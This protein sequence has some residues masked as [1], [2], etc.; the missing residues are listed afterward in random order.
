MTRPDSFAS[1]GTS[2]DDPIAIIG[3]G[4][5]FPGSSD[6]PR[7]FWELMAEGRDGI[8][9]VPED[10]WNVDRFWDPDPSKPGKMYVK[11][12]G[13]LRQRIDQ[14][15]ALFFGMSPREAE[16][17]DP[18]QRILLEVAWEAF[19]DAGIA[20]EKLAGS[21][22]GVYIGG[23]M[24]DGMLTQ[25][26]PLNRALIGT[27]TAVSS[28]LSI[29]ANRLSYVFD[30]RGPNIAMDTACSSSLVAVHQA[31]QALRRKECSLALAGGVNVMYRPEN[32]IS[33]CK[34]GFLSKDGRSKSFDARADGYGRGEGA[35]IVVL[36]KLSD[37]L[38]DEDEIYAVIRGT[39]VNQDGRTNGITVPNPES[40]E[41][42]VRR[43]CRDAGVDPRNIRYFE[44]HG[45]GTSVGDPLEARALGAVVGTGRDPANPCIV[46]SVKA[47]I[48]HLEAAS[49]VAGIIK[50]A[51]CL[52][53]RQIPPIANLETPNPNI[54]FEE[55]GLRLPKG[56]ETMPSGIGPALVGVNS[57]G[58]GGTNA[59]AILEEAP[60]TVSNPCD[61]TDTGP[62][63]LPFSARSPIALKTLAS[64]YRNLV[65]NDSDLKLRDLSYSASVRRS[66]HELRCAVV[67]NTREELLQRLSAV[68]E[69]TPSSGVSLGDCAT[70]GHKPVFVFSGMG[71]Q[72]WAM[73]RELYETDPVFRETASKVDETFREIAG[74]S[75]LGEMLADEAVSR[76][77]ETQIAQP[78]NF[79]LQA[80]LAEMWQTRGIK[81]AAV[82]GHSVGEVTA[83][84]LAGV[85]S[86]EDAVAVSFHRSRIQKK[87]AGLG[88]MLAVGL[89]EADASA[90]LAQYGDRVSVAAAN[91]PSSTTLAGDRDALESIAA[92][93]ER[94]GV[95]NRFLRVE[96]AYHS[97][98][99]DPLRPELLDSLSALRPRVPEIPLYSTVTGEKVT[100]I[101]Y[102]A[103]YWCRNVREPVYF[104]RA[105]D[106]ML[107]DG[108]RLFL[109]VGPHPVLSTSIREC[110]R[111]KATEC[112]VVASLRRG[113]PE[114]STFL[115]GLGEL[116]TAGAEID[117]KLQ[118]PEG[119]RF[120]KM[121]TYP[122]QRE[123]YWHESIASLT[124][125]LGE[126]A[127]PLLGSRM[128][129]PE[130]AWS[131]ALNPNFLPYLN[132]HKVDGLVVLPGAAYVELGF[133]VRS[134]AGYGTEGALEDLHFHKALVIGSSEEPELR[135]VYHRSTREFEIYSRNGDGSP[136]ML[137]AAG[138]LSLLSLEEQ[139]GQDM[140][141]IRARCRE[142]REG[143]MH[144]R[145]MHA[146]G[147]EYGP[148]FQ[149]VRELWRDEDG[150]E[151]LA[152]IERKESDTVNP[153][154]G[155]D[156]T[157][158]DA[159]FQ[160]LLELLDGSD[161]RIYVPVSIRRVSLWE[162]LGSRILCHGRKTG[163]TDDTLV[164]DIRLCDETGKVLAEVRGVCAKALNRTEE[165]IQANLDH[166]FYEYGWVRSETD[167]SQNAPAPSGRWL[168]LQDQRGVGERVARALLG[169]G[170]EV[171]NVRRGGHFKATGESAF[172]VS[173]GDREELVR[174]FKE[175]N[176]S[177]LNGIL[178]FWSLDDSKEADPVG[179]E[180]TGELLN[181]IQ[182]LAEV[183]PE[184]PAP[185][186]ILTREAQPV[187]PGETETDLSETPLVG[188][189]R[190]AANEYPEQVFRSID[191][192]PSEDSL[193]LLLRELVAEDGEEE[194][195]Y[196]GGE[197]YVRRL[198]RK[199]GAELAA[200]APEPR[201][202]AAM[203]ELL[204]AEVAITVHGCAFDKREQDSA[205]SAGTEVF[206]TGLI[207]ATARGVGQLR[208]GDPV[209]A[210]YQGD[211]AESLILSASEVVPL[212]PISEDALKAIP[213]RVLPYIMAHYALRHM[214]RIASG[215]LVLIHEADTALGLA[216]VQAAL[217]VGAEVFV[218]VGNPAREAL[219]K[220][221]GPVRVVNGRSP[222]LPE[223]VL[224]MTS[225]RGVDAAVGV[226]RGEYAGKVL[227][228]LAPMGCMVSVVDGPEDGRLDFSGTTNRSIFRLCPKTLRKESPALF[229]QLV[230][231]VQALFENSSYAPE[232]LA[233]LD[234]AQS[235]KHLAGTST[236]GQSKRRVFTCRPAA[237]MS[238][239]RADGT[240]L[241][242][243]GFGGF[244]MEMSRWMAKQGV[245]HLVL[246]GRQGAV[247]NEAK[248]LVARLEKS[249]VHVFPA[250]ADISRE[251]DVITLLDQVAETMPPLR[252]IF[253]AAAVLDD[254]PLAFSSPERFAAVM[255]PKA[256][257]AWH[258]HCHTKGLPLDMFV[259]FSSISALIGNPAQ[260][261]YVAANAVLNALAHVR[262]AWGLP[263]ISINWG[264][265]SEV[266]MVAKDG[267]VEEYFKRVGIGF[268]NPTQALEVLANILE[269][270][271]VEVAAAVID[272]AQWGQYN[273]A[274]AASPRYRHLIADSDRP[275]VGAATNEFGAALSTLPSEEHHGYATRVLVE[276][277]S[278]IMR[279]PVDK[280][281]PRQSLVN[282]GVDSLIA[283]ELQAA[284]GRKTGAKIST[285]ELMKGSAIEHLASQ[286][287][288][289]VETLEPNASA[290]LARS[291]DNGTGSIIVVPP[292][293]AVDD[294]ALL[295]RLNDL[296]E[297]ELDEILATLM[298][299]C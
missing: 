175:V 173:P 232:V 143:K 115:T 10:R 69:G 221:Q 237:S 116:Y 176:P 144:Y 51:L 21:D 44:A 4:C 291:P 3:I 269:W 85:L 49:G 111:S 167:S 127:H 153:R 181:L 29:L 92:E 240:Y 226:F 58:Y 53:H 46:G 26:S 45:T 151:V 219:V 189:L 60:E 222:N 196:R 290:A 292:K 146:R 241:I 183:G 298:K 199:P 17:L 170:V 297:D 168:V 79:V 287:L 169:Y 126:P 8:T 283:M 204:D 274:W 231:E 286:V 243:G 187:V 252:G 6:S 278:E 157:L 72:W 166:W 282:L 112:L 255:R 104:A 37:A 185:L 293:P 150:T 227:E 224:D 95:F 195:A 177:N 1:D 41:N 296:S 171:V 27:H 123:T 161:R 158:L 98:Y 178:Y 129:G 13:F 194:I 131:Q 25:L 145:A 64:A 216:A 230:H 88:T 42:L 128:D 140:E 198:N 276:L 156:P 74:W 281:D 24:L 52:K 152:C 122:W 76:M 28:T 22:T 32:P 264:A 254:S 15:D 263:A 120:V 258:L 31:C 214:A 273:P 119:G 212:A 279:I 73:G 101:A 149:G 190:V 23:F 148:W 261:A 246:V 132:D 12:G 105:M 84:Y 239:F 114:Q 154:E 172:R 203:D 270:N 233:A 55:L 265:L 134:D 118:H 165:G 249:G 164:G 67:A 174:L 107:A 220:Q 234:P 61:K 11:A 16:Y 271:P 39:G 223:L 205:A 125:R 299:C 294:A 43:V 259:L 137:H 211:P 18:Q 66:H 260:G 63:I 2:P 272:C 109:E 40:Q 253:H 14:F 209:L 159:C 186:F 250:A 30:L 86:L 93:L 138:R 251:S 50:A 70:K 280:I 285:L 235:D 160:T 87:A 256:L 215:Q 229:A 124:D 59:H 106:S 121:P 54:P 257:G 208:V 82:V 247:S 295:E 277:V 136:W 179:I 244:G 77:A 113:E 197:R 75:I 262:R 90:V 78:A 193:P 184:K 236:S 33:M 188:L 57:F 202:Q 238:P 180:K 47:N 191:L 275:G 266:G 228:A 155:I 242:T 248:E 201:F 83:A 142:H 7:A 288:A 68:A 182:A 5:R 225:G 97:P 245:R 94:Q 117:W 217:A 56:L 268:F 130:D 147:L 99:M 80:A 91:S 38:R 289:A 110:A 62:W 48:G 141:P 96:V 20:A 218:T 139:P 162:R 192:D 135:T 133:G 267:G 206:A 35:G 210:V 71:P 200:A 108:H 81:P 284:I 213:G 102:D 207:T 100:G 19:E 163:G 36:K 103:E 65:E 34:G 9:E 89:G